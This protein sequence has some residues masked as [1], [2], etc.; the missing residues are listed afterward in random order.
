M[1]LSHLR[2]YVTSLF[3]DHFCSRRSAG[4][5]GLGPQSISLE[6]SRTTSCACGT[7]SSQVIRTRLNTPSHQV[8]FE[9]NQRELRE[10]ALSHRETQVQQREL[11]LVKLELALREVSLERRELAIFAKEQ[12]IEG[13][14]ASADL[15]AVFGVEGSK[16]IVHVLQDFALFQVCT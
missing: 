1:P 14:T 10:V 13:P 8:H 6:A 5:N 4:D 12:A 3:K 16:G 7:S 11:D 15:I 9:F 2:I